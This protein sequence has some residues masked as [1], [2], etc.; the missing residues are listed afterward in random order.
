MSNF[1]RQA[2]VFFFFLF[3]SVTPL[4]VEAIEVS[5]V[6]SIHVGPKAI[7]G[8]TA[9]DPLGG[10]SLP[11]LQGASPL[12]TVTHRFS[13]ENV[14]PKPGDSISFSYSPDFPVTSFSNGSVFSGNWCQSLNEQCVSFA[15]TGIYNVCIPN[16]PS[17]VGGGGCYTVR[18]GGAVF[19]GTRP[20]ARAVSS[21]NSVIQCPTSSS[22]PLTCRVLKQGSATISFETSLLPLKFWV[23]EYDLSGNLLV[24]QFFSPSRSLNDFFAGGPYASMFNALP[25]PSASV[26]LESFIYS[27]FFFPDFNVNERGYTYSTMPT[28]EY[29]TTYGDLIDRMPWPL[30]SRYIYN[31]SQLAGWNLEMNLNLLFGG[32]P[33]IALNNPGLSWLMPLLPFHELKN[34]DIGALPGETFRQ[35]IVRKFPTTIPVVSE[36]TPGNRTDT[37]FM[38]GFTEIPGIPVVV[39]E[40]EEEDQNR[41]PNPPVVVPESPVMVGVYSTVTMTATDPDSDEIRY[42][43]DWNM[44][45]DSNDTAVSGRSDPEGCT[46]FVPSGTSRDTWQSWESEGT[47]TFQV[48]TE[49]RGGLFSAWTRATVLV[50]TGG[51]TSDPECGNNT[52]EGSEQCDVTDLGGLTCASYGFSQGSLS[53]RANCTINA[54]MC[55]NPG[56]SSGSCG[57]GTIEGTEPCDDG[58]TVGGDGCSAQCQI[59]STTNPICVENDICERSRGENFFNCSDCRG[60]FQ[61]F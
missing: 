57:N 37:V 16:S 9:G 50:T 35:A 54:S 14:N 6:Q 10:F 26:P 39:D 7:A 61:E 53:C 25:W 33:G 41:P 28:S 5:G 60:I 13:T 15:P 2:V 20:N 51:G 34:M 22:S 49:D 12:V 27:D 38:P 1:L 29:L 42:C 44:D 46:A 24:D 47:K 17:V 55:T 31:G 8:G 43:I 59:E 19:T 48:R 11:N 30:T 45:G 40:P 23:W 21:D 58:N 56:G 3:F 32:L 18:I 36:F 52:R 4:S